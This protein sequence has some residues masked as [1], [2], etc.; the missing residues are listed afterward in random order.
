MLFY[1]ISNSDSDTRTQAVAV[2]ADAVLYMLGIVGIASNWKRKREFVLP[3]MAV[4]FF[5]IIQV[6]LHAEARYRLPLMP[7]FCI[8][9]AIGVQALIR[10]EERIALLGDKTK[11]MLVACGVTVVVAVYAYTG[12]MFLRGSI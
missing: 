7:L 11:K 6:V 5:I 4:L 2:A 8:P 3:M 1:P 12:W 9:A 10:K